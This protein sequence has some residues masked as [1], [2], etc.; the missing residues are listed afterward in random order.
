MKMIEKHY[1]KAT[2]SLFY[3]F[4]KTVEFFAEVLSCNPL[5]LYQRI[6]FFINLE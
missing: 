2:E 6:F 1:P 5:P 4:F 3:L